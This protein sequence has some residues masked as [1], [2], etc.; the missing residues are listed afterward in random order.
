MIIPLRFQAVQVISVRTRLSASRLQLTYSHN[1]Q[2]SCESSNAPH[3]FHIAY[4][5]TLRYATTQLGSGT[6]R[7]RNEPVSGFLLLLEVQ[8]QA[9]RGSCGYER[10]IA[11]DDSHEDAKGL[12]FVLGRHRGR[13]LYGM[14]Q[15]KPRK[16][17]GQ[18]SSQQTSNQQYPRPL[19]DIGKSQ[20]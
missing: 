5:G 19:H 14:S 20:R 11:A 4:D 13:H 9:E 16:K 8:P 18:R 12:V 10:R 6:K 2:E 15:G 7:R 3:S 1:P 17:R